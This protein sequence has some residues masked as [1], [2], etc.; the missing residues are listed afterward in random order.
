MIKIEDEEIFSLCGRF[1][2]LLFAV[3]A[4]SQASGLAVYKGEG[5]SGQVEDGVGYLHGPLLGG[6]PQG[7]RRGFERK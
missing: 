4:A 7:G 2:P 1:L 6:H 5:G 3:C